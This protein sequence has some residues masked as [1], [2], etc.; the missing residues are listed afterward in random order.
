M[1]FDR[2]IKLEKDINYVLVGVRRAGKSTILY[3][4]AKELVENGAD[5]NQ[6]IYINFDDD[7]LKDL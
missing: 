2:E 7:R 5:W 1:I 6:I 4:R 3:K